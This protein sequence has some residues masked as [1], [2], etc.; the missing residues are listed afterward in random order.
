MDR[1]GFCRTASI[2]L[3]TM[4]A[5]GVG[6]AEEKR[7][8]VLYPKRTASKEGKF[9]WYEA[10]IARIGKLQHERGSRW[11]MITWEGF[12]TQP[13]KPEYYRDLLARGLAQHIRMDVHMIETALAIQQ[14]GSPVIVM[15]GNSGTF[16]ASLAGGPTAWAHQFDDGYKPKDYTRPCPAIHL[17]WAKFADK[18]RDTLREFKRS[19]VQIDA[20]WMDWENDPLYGEDRYDQARHCTRCRAILP[21]KV[22]SSEDLFLDY[23]S[24][25]FYDLFGAYYAAPVLEYY[26]K[27]SVTNW[28]AQPS[29]PEARQR[30][31][32]GK[33]G[34]VHMPPLVT[35]WN[36]TAYG[37]ASWVWKT[38]RKDQDQE[39]VD[40]RYTNVLLRQVSLT[41]KLGA[42]WA[43]EKEMIPWVTRWVSEPPE[44]E[45]PVMT[46]ERYREVLRHLWLRGIAGMQIFN[47]R[48]NGYEDMALPELEDAVQV[49]DEMLSFR[50]FMEKGDVLNLE[51]PPEQDDG[52]VWSGIRLGN[53]AAVRLCKQGGG[54]ATQTVRP[55]GDRDFELEA[56]TE[57]KT[58]MLGPDGTVRNVAN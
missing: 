48:M 16:P 2:G 10:V 44:T 49:Y 33:S 37:A 4:L 51:I 50:E 13:Q 3:A 29:L 20:V 1:R 34:R 22:L 35:A 12:S 24:R 30:G 5:G 38:R 36:P 54:K 58:Y 14:A 21:Q 27:C 53:R 55:W 7:Q 47:P 39:H 26:P 40:Q 6:Q 52:V 43:P 25:K 41:A 31:W 32:S 46:R 19:G 56:N 23:T 11:P 8:G 17:G 28:D 57:G 15:E 45:F 42:R 9:S 18:L